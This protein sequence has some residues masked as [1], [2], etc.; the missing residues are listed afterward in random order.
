MNKRL[1]LLLAILIPIFSFGQE[2]FGN[3]WINYDQEYYKIMVD[4]D[5]MYRIDRQTMDSAGLPVNTIDPDLFQMF[6]KGEEIN[7][8]VETRE[9]G[10]VDYIDFYGVRNDGTFDTQLYIK[11]EYQ[12]HTFYNLFSNFSAYFLTW[13]NQGTPGKRIPFI[14]YDDSG[15]LDTLEYHMEEEL[16]IFDEAYSAGQTFNGNLFSSAYDLGEGWTSQIINNK[17]SISYEIENHFFLDSLKIEGLFR[18]LRFGNHELGILISIQGNEVLN[19]SINLVDYNFNN[20]SIN[21]PFNDDFQQEDLTMNLELNNVNGNP[22]ISYLEISYPQKNDMENSLSKVLNI[23]PGEMEDAILKVSNSPF[24]V[25][26]FNISDIYNLSEIETRSTIGGFNS[27]LRNILFVEDKLYARSGAK[28]LTNI[29]K[30]VIN[31]I[32]PSE[33]NFLLVTNK[34]LNQVDENNI[35]PISEY[36][37]YR[38]SVIGGGFN[39]HTINISE[40]YNQFSYGLQSPLAIKKYCEFMNQNGNPMFLF[41]VGKGIQSFFRNS[42]EDNLVTTFGFPGSDVLFSYGISSDPELEAIPT[43]R[44]NATSSSDILSYLDKV[45]EHE[46][47]PFNDLSRKNFLNLSGGLNLIEQNNFRSHINDFTDIVENGIVGGKGINISKETSEAVEQ[48]NVVDEINNGTLLVTFF[49][50]SSAG[51]ADIRIGNASDPS[52]GYNNK[53]RYPF[54]YVNGCNSGNFFLLNDSW[55]VDWVLTPQLG[56]IGFM[57]HS[58][59]ALSSDLKRQADIFFEVAFNDNDFI[60]K[61]IG[62]IKAEVGRRYLEQ[63]GTSSRHLAQVRQLCL[64]GDPAIKLFTNKPDFDIQNTDLSIKG[65]NNESV[66]AR[67]DSFLI[68]MNIRNFGRSVK[69]SLKIQVTRNYSD[70]TTEKIGPK[71]FPSV[72]RLDTLEFSISQ[73]NE[74]PG[75]NTFQIEID[76][77][78]EVDE[79]SKSNNA[80]IIESFFPTGQINNLLPLNFGIQESNKVL[81]QFQLAGNQLENRVYLFEIDTTSKFN[82][83]S[84]KSIET[85]ENIIVLEIVDLDN[86]YDDSLVVYWRSRLVNPKNFEDTSWFESNFT[87]LNNSTDDWLQFRKNQFF[88]GIINGLNIND[89]IKW[90]FPDNESGLGVVTHGGDTAIGFDNISVSVVGLNLA[91]LSEFT[92]QNQKNRETCR[93]NSMNFVVFDQQSTVQKRPIQ[94]DEFD[95]SN[96][97]LCGAQP[98]FIY[99]YNVD[100][101]NNENKASILLETVEDGDFVVAFTFG[102]IDYESLNDRTLEAFNSIGV[103]SGTFENLVTGQPLIIFGQKGMALGEATVVSDNGSDLPVQQ[104]EISLNTVIPGKFFSGSYEAPRI[105]PAQTWKSLNLDLKSEPSDNVNIQVTGQEFTG[106]ENV[107]LSN[108]QSGITSLA[109]ID[110]AQYPYIKLKMSTNDRENLTAPQL[111]SW[112]VD[113]DPSP[114]GILLLNEDLEELNNREV[115]EGETVKTSFIF[116]NLSE[117]DFQDS[118]FVSIQTLNQTTGEFVRD[119]LVLSNVQGGDSLVFDYDFQ[120]LGKAGDH[121]ITVFANPQRELEREFGNNQLQIDDFITVVPDNTNPILD[122]TFDG[123]Y[124][125]DGDIVSPSPFINITLKDENQ[126]NF[127]DDTTGVNLF[128]KKPCEDCEFERI[129]FSNPRVEWIP[130]NESED[131]KIN[132]QPENLENGIYGFR[133]QASDEAGNQAGAQPYSINFEIINESTVTNFYPYPNPFSSSVRFVFT[134]TG[135]EIPDQIKI[136]IMTVSGRIVRE[137]TQDEIGPIKI[138]N[139]ITEFAWDGRDEYGDQLANGVYLY[140]VMINNDGQPMDNRATAGDK[141][142]KRG[143]G[144]MYLMR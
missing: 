34:I 143:F 65:F 121:N 89:K 138:G 75:E 111:K 109:S 20:Y 72:K 6:Y 95:T 80:A 38:E 123:N 63:Y 105:G 26:L 51:G 68:E 81:F 49:G 46:S 64:Q 32:Q 139:N 47:L 40:I 87:F 69:D 43:G 12:P 8:K 110:A 74:I 103:N 122:V 126:F 29:Q 9:D 41:L 83:L 59:L 55:G 134:L 88:K 144:K 19:E 70:N 36:T 1:L 71:M 125:L 28:E 113:Y 66:T 133:V 112:A 119:S 104:Q 91:S 54:F 99:T 30:V 45:K 57:S 16:I 23:I 141:A 115:Q 48:I 22:S 128:L 107:I 58:R 7:I 77:L 5:D 62:I 142:F 97:D 3:E 118:V 129:S 130:A 101:I 132:Y 14:E 67:S 17:E 27:T 114:E 2:K 35:N 18:G 84:K 10:T 136:Q 53:G 42:Q 31:R 37:Q 94:F 44:I 52:I 39:V 60:G 25:R 21:I 135:S 117:S 86:I 24:D 116:W 92:N 120:T 85:S 102:T 108:I 98:Q 96:P 137:I 78:N 11:P 73:S 61:E 90:S 13:N 50:H 4:E 33:Y 100:Q 93:S 131:F 82:S 56:A 106:E 140:R 124:I 76:P 127:K 79:L 15:D